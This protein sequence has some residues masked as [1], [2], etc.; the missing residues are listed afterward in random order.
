MGKKPELKLVLDDWGLSKGV[1]DG[2]LDLI[3]TGAVQ[4]VSVLV[5]TSGW[6]E[7]F[8]VLAGSSIELSLHLNFTWGT[9]L[10]SPED[11]PSLLNPQGYFWGLRAFSFRYFRGLLCKRE[12][13]LEGSRQWEAFSQLAGR[14]PM[15]VEGHHNIHMLPDVLKSVSSVA[16]HGAKG[17]IGYREIEGI[18]LSGPFWCQKFSRLFFAPPSKPWRAWATRSVPIHFFRSPES[19][20]RVWQPGVPIVAHP[21]RQDDLYGLVP[22]DGMLERRQQRDTL[23]ETLADFSRQT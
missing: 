22:P 19:L 8:S 21:A 17:A 6:K 4:R 23:L 1:N 18:L 5:T 13:E 3:E 12:M 14:P 2:V 9:P 20:L 15:G 11:I 7:D 16:S 10:S